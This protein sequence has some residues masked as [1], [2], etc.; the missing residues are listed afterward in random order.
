MKPYKLVPLDLYRK[1]LAIH[2][3]QSPQQ[4]TSVPKHN[5]VVE[6]E[7]ED[8]EAERQESIDSICQMLGKNQRRKARIIL[9]TGKIPFQR[10]S[11][12]VMYGGQ[13]MGSH[14]LGELE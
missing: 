10:K 2:T 1:L 12:R 11:L 8:E 13:D 9:E 7:D 3:G 4:G 5:L 6:E 14:I